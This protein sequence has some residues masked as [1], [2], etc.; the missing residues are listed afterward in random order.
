MSNLAFLN[1]NCLF[2]NIIG[3]TFAIQIE[4]S[5]LPAGLNVGFIHA[6][7][8]KDYSRG[9]LFEIPVT[10]A[11]PEKSESNV[12]E[13]SGLSFS[14][15]KMSRF[16]FA[17]PAKASHAEVKIVANQLELPGRYVFHS[18]QI[19]P[20][21]RYARTEVQNYFTVD[22]E[23]DSF[24]KIIPLEGGVPLEICICPFWST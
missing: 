11:K 7:D 2:V 20:G 1:Y 10:V 9:V 18:N 17:I 4:P 6:Y 21:K 15:G 13:K 12:F 23:Q 22:A 8:S 24:E 14:A 19:V 3:R 5:G 16:F